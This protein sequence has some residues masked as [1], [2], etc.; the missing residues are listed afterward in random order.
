MGYKLCK[1]CENR[2][3]DTP[4]RGVYIPHFGQIWVK[5]SVLGV[6]HPYRCTDGVR[7]GMGPFLHAKFHPHRCNV[8]PLRGEKPQ[9]R[10]LSK[11]NTSACAARNAA[12]N[13]LPLMRTSCQEWAGMETLLSWN[14]PSNSLRPRQLLLCYIWAHLYC[15]AS[16][17]SYHIRHTMIELV[18]WDGRMGIGV[19]TA[20]KN[21]NISRNNRE[22][23]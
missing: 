19:Q 10:P 5:I 9:N 8:S 15:W 2:A 23:E 6:L 18:E 21:G 1:F 4:L 20:G 22:L 13:E 16:L 11:L 3:R 17:V 12:G 14:G 7:F